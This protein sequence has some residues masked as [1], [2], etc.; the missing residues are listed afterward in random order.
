MFKKHENI[1]R[2]FWLFF[3]KKFGSIQP[4]RSIGH[5]SISSLLEC[6]IQWN[7]RTFL[8]Y[9]TELNMASRG[10]N[11][12]NISIF[13]RVRF[14]PNELCFNAF[15]WFLWVRFDR[16]E[17]EKTS[18]YWKI[19]SL[20]SVNFEVRFDRTELLTKKTQK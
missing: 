10:P 18:K 4:N 5:N 9:R 20:Y 1:F 17:L 19:V 6:I 12:F 14:D 2:I 16:T 8:A 7:S 11:F 13:F 3:C 15:E